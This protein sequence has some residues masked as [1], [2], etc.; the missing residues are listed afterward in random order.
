MAVLPALRL[1]AGQDRGGTTNDNPDRGGNS[2]GILWKKTRTVCVCSI[3]RD[4]LM[5]RVGDEI[6]LVPKMDWHL[7]H[8]NSSGMCGAC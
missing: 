4:D 2:L 8:L 5:T 6:I 3:A 1:M 7:F